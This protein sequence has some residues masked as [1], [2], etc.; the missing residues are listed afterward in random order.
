MNKKFK[1]I[2]AII[3]IGLIGFKFPQ[4][5]R[6]FLIV[7]N[8]DIFAT[9]YK[10]VNAYYVD[11]VNPNKIIRTGIDA[12]LGS[13]DPYTAYIPEDAIEDYRTYTTG[14][15]AGIGAVVEERNGRTTIIMP[16]E[17]YAAHKAGLKIGDEIHQID[18][19]DLT[20]KSQEDV[21]NLLKGQSQSEVTL[22]IK[23]YGKPK[24]FDVKLQHEKVKINSVPYFGIVKDD[25]GYIRLSEFT[26]KAGNKVGEALRALKD[27]GAA[28]IILDLR[29]NPG[30]LLEEAINVSNIFIPK[31]LEVVSTKGKRSK[32]TKTYNSLNNP[33]DTDIPLVVLINHS[34]ASASEIVAGVVQDY[35]RGILIGRKSFG[36]GLVQQTRPLVYNSQLKVTTAKYYIPS[37]RCIQSIDYGN[38]NESGGVGKIPDSLKVAFKTLGGRVVFDGGG[39]KPDID[40]ENFLLSDISHSLLKNDLIFNYVTEYVFKNGD[41]FENTRDFKFKDEEYQQFIDWLSDKEYEYYTPMEV[42]VDRLTE[43]ALKSNQGDEIINQ[44][45]ELEKTTSKDKNRDLMDHKKEISALIERDIAGRYMLIKGLIESSFGKDRDILA[46]A[47]ILNDQEAYQNILGTN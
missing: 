7:K 21:A 10:E 8:L 3:F 31:G 19:V 23:R 13:L 46:A 36:K 6:Y 35:D 4:D 28:K 30:G 24:H 5:D 16:Y 17:G 43:V 33:V 27:R 34:S 2:I 15:Y 9:L 40:V 22:T 18:G 11:E 25:I 20:G 12:M 29:N 1:F 45:K 26:T 14:E 47:K 44:I 32:W 42:A 39:V 41:R 37:G 38:R